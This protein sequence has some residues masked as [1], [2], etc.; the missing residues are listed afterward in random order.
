VT[1]NSEKRVPALRFKGFTNDWEQRKLEEITQR[2]I[3]KN[4]NLTSTLPLTISA[5]YGLVDQRI[6]FEKQIA[7]K[8]LETYL[9][10]K[11]GEFAYNKSYSKDY[12]FGTIKRL[13]N[14]PMGVLSTLYIAFKPTLTD[15]NFLEQYFD[16]SKWYKEIYKR[17]TEGARNHGLLNISPQDFFEIIINQPKNK[18]EQKKISKI[19]KLISLLISLQQRKLRQLNFIR[20]GLT[21]NLFPD[22]DKIKPKVQ[23]KGYKENWKITKAKNIFTE[24]D[25]RELPDRVILSTTQTGKV[26]TRSSL[27][28]NLLFSKDKLKNY[29]L[30]L[31]GQ[32]IIHLRSFKGG[33]ATSELSGIVSPTYTIFDFKDRKQ[34]DSN[35]WSILFT[36]YNFIQSLKS[37]TEGIRYNGVTIKFNQFADLKITYPDLEIQSRLSQL[38]QCLDADIKKQKL[39]IQKFKKVKQFLLQNMFT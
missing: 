4:T 25:I 11:Q 10:L 23:F 7:S 34:N 21:Q 37:I 15:T 28:R 5:Q 35:F 29:K 8:K 3:R 24:V 2:I 32:F 30:V 31:P 17:A 19:L 38:I 13:N 39:K 33:F 18:R 20:Q 27:G 26:V 22:K 16:S 12:P 9:L 1:K 14:Y 36:H 6:Y